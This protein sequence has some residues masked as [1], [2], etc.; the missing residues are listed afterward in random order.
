MHGD[1]HHR[2]LGLD[3]A[4]E[5]LPGFADVVAAE[6]PAV[7]AAAEGWAQSG[8]KHLRIMRGDPQIA[9]IGQRREP[10]D[11]DVAPMRPAIVTAEE[12]HAVGEK[13]RARC[14][15][16]AGDCMAVE[17]AFDLGLTDDAAL[18]FLLLGKAQ[19]ILGVQSSQL[20]PRSRLRILPLASMQA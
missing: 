2:R 1:A 9:A 4:V 20:S 11:L 14:G 6:D 13:H 7:A 17:H 15:R 5:A 12:T 16:T 18:V 3:P 8:I 10:A 19:Q